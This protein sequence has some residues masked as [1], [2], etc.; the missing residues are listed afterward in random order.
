M[1]KKASKIS[2][3]TALLLSL[4]QLPVPAQNAQNSQ[5]ASQ[6]VVINGNNNEVTQ[7][8]NQD[9]GR[10]RKARR[11]RA[12]RRKRR[13]FNQHLAGKKHHRRANHRVYGRDHDDDDDDDRD[14]D[15]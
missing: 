15:D 7:I 6:G 9:I 12:R 14:D 4:V 2:L 1:F 11:R 5:G 8:I 10:G 13:R 3:T